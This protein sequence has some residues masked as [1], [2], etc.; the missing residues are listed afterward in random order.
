MTP[1]GDSG[2]RGPAAGFSLIELLATV[3]VFG[4]LSSIAFG[5]FRQYARSTAADRAASVLV[6]DLARTRSYAVQRR[7][8][9]SLVVDEAN[10]SYQI[11]VPG[12]PVLAVQDFGGSD[13]PLTL[14]DLQMADSALFNARG[15]LVTGPLQVELARY[16]ARRRVEVN[17]VGRTR[18]TTP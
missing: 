4:I 2:A 18:V 12:G 8:P 5:A 6:G 3:I 13:T 9:V 17:A 16:D 7:G 15:L 14:L 1:R 10:R 11:R